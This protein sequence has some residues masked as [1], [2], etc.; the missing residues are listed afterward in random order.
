MLVGMAPKGKEGIKG[1]GR[2]SPPPG[3]SEPSADPV[4]RARR[5]DDMSRD[6]TEPLDDNEATWLA[7][8]LG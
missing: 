4:G 8:D 6:L 3:A 5:Q 7:A 1:S 2:E